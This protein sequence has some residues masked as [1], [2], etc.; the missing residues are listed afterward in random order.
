MMSYI[1]P[2]CKAVYSVEE[3][4]K[5]KFC[6]SCGTFL[7]KHQE[8]QKRNHII[9][10]IGENANFWLVPVREADSIKRLIVE[11][12]IWAYGI[13]T[14]GRQ[15]IKPN[16]W[17]CFHLSE[18]GIVAHA[19]VLTYPEKMRHPK[20]K[21]PVQYPWVF[22]LGN[23]SVYL[24]DPIKISEKIRRQLDAF[25]DDDLISKENSIRRWGWFVLNNKNISMQDF[26]ILTNTSLS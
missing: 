14:P 3:Y 2:R 20:V 10:G 5:D 24:Q 6:S 16:D 22:S 12:N 23:I 17:A 21:D 13:N 25:K 1:C 18:Y 8:S 4:S 9:I 15:L 19:K 26:N 7:K 11:G